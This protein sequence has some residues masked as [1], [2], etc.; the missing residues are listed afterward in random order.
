MDMVNVLD[1][2][3]MPIEQTE[4]D[5]HDGNQQSSCESMKRKEEFS[6]SGLIS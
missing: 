2:R 3:G 1:A 5:A 4:V 6:A